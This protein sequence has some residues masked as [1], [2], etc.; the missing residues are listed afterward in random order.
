MPTHDLML[1]C[2]FA[3]V[4]GVAGLL[5]ADRLRFPSIVFLLAFGT[6]LGPDGAG[7][8]N[9]ESL[10][11]GL[12]ILVKIAVAIILFEGALTLRARDMAEVFA[13]V[14]RMVTLG[15]GITWAGASL[16]GY[17]ICGLPG[18]L[19]VLFGALVTVTGPTVIRPLLERV[20]VKRNVATVLNSEGV[21]IDPIGVFAAV[22]VLELILG[23]G[24]TW[25][26]TLTGYIGRLGIGAAV[27]AAGGFLLPWVLRARWLVAEHLQNLAGLAGVLLIF[28]VS[29]YFSAESG[30]A[31][32]VAAGLAAPRRI[33]P[34]EHRF[35]LFKEELTLLFISVLFILLAANVRLSSI[36]AEGWRGVA[37]VGVLMF[38]VRPLCVFVSLDGRKLTFR[39]RLFIAA[40]APRGVVAASAASLFALILEEKGWEGARRIEA[41]V[42]LTIA[43]TVVV[44]GILAWPVAWVLGVLSEAD[45]RIIVVGANMVGRALAA[46]FHSAG[47]PVIVTDT[48]P[49]HC[50]TARG[51]GIPTACGNI[52]ER[53]HQ[54][55]IGMD[56]AGTVV[57]V[58][59][60]PEVNLLIAQHAREDYRIAHVYVALDR[61]DKGARWEHVHR[62]G[63]RL[64]FGRPVTLAPWLDR[65]RDETAI[66]VPRET[67]QEDPQPQ[68]VRDFAENE[69]VVPLLVC[70]G[71]RVSLC[72]A[73][74]R[75][76]PG[77][78]VLFLTRRGSIVD[79]TAGS[80]SGTSSS[81]PP[82]PPAPSSVTPEGP[83]S[84][85]GPSS[86]SSDGIPP[87][88]SLRPFTGLF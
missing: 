60:N 85:V 46:A 56:E 23:F 53:A 10:G 8:V 75:W 36:L 9:P 3:V 57:A 6:A 5:V 77:D 38:V 87:P 78:R 45:R 66:L 50:E 76:L 67:P 30:L 51:A 1:M 69:D 88:S 71:D 43:I 25:R 86:S 19:A 54:D 72:D 40:V 15:L 74:T 17:W 61:F 58:T 27:G 34:Q 39:D 35:R 13:G 44:Q 62:I 26:E 52:F 2:V 48:N 18:E 28:A 16:A 63:G 83:E 20:H 11:R 81:A 82:V 47:Y 49:I 29:E 73:T 14:R 68:T 22:L 80:S 64:A 31:A 12:E 65:L 79:V 33:M 70:R 55:R 21:I 4:A 7:L 32:V 84:P 59:P 24:T 37:L 41:L 42:F